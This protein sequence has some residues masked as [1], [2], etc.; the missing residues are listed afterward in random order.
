VR[1]ARAEDVTSLAALRR[2]GP[3]VAPRQMLLVLDEVLTRAPGHGQFQELRT[4]CP[5][6]ADTCRYLSGM[7][8]SADTSDALAALRTLLLN[9]GWDAYWQSYQ[10]CYLEA[11]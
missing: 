8:W 1:T 11:A 2:L 7:Q 9:E 10:P 3:E 6:T 5:L 4:A